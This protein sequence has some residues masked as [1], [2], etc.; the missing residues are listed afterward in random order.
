MSSWCH[1]L[2]HLFCKFIIYILLLLSLSFILFDELQLI[3]LH[4]KVCVVDDLLR[5]VLDLVKSYFQLS[6]RFTNVLPVISF[7]ITYVK[8]GVNL[9]TS[10]AWVQSNGKSL[11]ELLRQVLYILNALSYESWNSI[12]FLP[13]FDSYRFLWVK[14]LYDTSGSPIL[15]FDSSH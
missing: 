12:K 7:R 5:G 10:G 1:L 6:Q 13:S 8:C 11:C 4:K 9:V 15:S 2:D 3:Y 14:K